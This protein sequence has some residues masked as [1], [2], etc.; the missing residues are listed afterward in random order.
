MTRSRRRAA[1]GTDL[2]TSKERWDR[3]AT[4]SLL[5]DPAYY[6]ES[7]WKGAIRF[8]LNEAQSHY[9]LS[10]EKAPFLLEEREIAADYLTDFCALVSGGDAVLPMEDVLRATRMTLRIQRKADTE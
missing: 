5:R 4:E 1:D 6:A 8:S 3:R 9:Y 7:P 10:G 2:T